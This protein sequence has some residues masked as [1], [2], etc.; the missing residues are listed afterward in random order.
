MKA[1]YKIRFPPSNLSL[2]RPCLRSGWSCAHYIAK[3]DSYRWNGEK[4]R[5]DVHI[6]TP[7]GGMRIA[8]IEQ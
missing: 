4:S 8:E 5:Y 7:S 6:S 3:V 1:G 2:G